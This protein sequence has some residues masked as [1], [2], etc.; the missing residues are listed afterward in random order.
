MNRYLIILG[1]EPELAVAELASVI[2]RDG[3]A[4]HIIEVTPLWALVEGEVSVDLFQTL[5]G[6]IKFAQVVGE[7]ELTSDALVA[8]LT[9]QLVARPNPR[10][11]FGISWHGDSR[12]PR[13][14]MG[15]GLKVKR[16]VKVQAHVRYVVSRDP[17]LSSVVV[18]KNHLLPPAGFEFII[19]PHLGKLL[20]SRTL[21]VQDFEAWGKRDFGRPGRD[22]RV[23]MLP[24]KLARIM[25]NLAAI[26]RTGV[27][28]DP[29]CGSGTVLQEAVLL[30]YKS[31][32]GA[33]NDIKGLA[34]TRQNFAWL[35]ENYPELVGIEPE[36]ITSDIQ[37]L[38][39]Q[40]K[41]SKFSAVVTEP[42]LG[43]PLT[44]REVPAQLASL[45]KQLTEFY[46]VTLKVMASLLVPGGRI[47]MVWPIL[48]SRQQEYPLELLS[49]L[50][51]AQ[52]RALSVL[53]EF[54]PKEWLAPRHTLRYERPDQHVVRE[55]VVLSHVTK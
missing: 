54:V 4:C 52:L 35:K 44:G 28:L 34:R 8:L 29:F 30:G 50:K 27:L 3:L 7:S 11:E 39:T 32:T 24:P 41:Q 43:P 10:V 53:P 1:R 20:I 48:R 9:E 36:L 42:Y 26:P 6:S 21:G 12:Y 33:D 47:V 31:V 22:A 2:E 46:R 15:V 17:A 55:I 18:A 37:H 38:P 45:Q 19:I 14:F 5:G 49:A 51:G 40:T 23:G 25:V 16:E 13:W